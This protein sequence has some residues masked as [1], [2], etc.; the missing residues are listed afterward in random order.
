MLG[1]SMLWAR[2]ALCLTHGLCERQL[3]RN[4]R[5]FLVMAEHREAL[6]AAGRW[7]VTVESSQ[8]TP[9][10]LHPSGT[11]RFGEWGSFWRLEKLIL[12]EADS[13]RAL[14]Q[15]GLANKSI[16]CPVQFAFEIKHKYFKNINCLPILSETR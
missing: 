1:A 2:R 3:K 7:D 8:G 9:Q 11:Q 13:P 15:P 16:E 4:P 5:G 12:A 14:W 10:L 6:P